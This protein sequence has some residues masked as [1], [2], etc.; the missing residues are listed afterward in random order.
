MSDASGDVSLARLAT[1]LAHSLRDLQ[2]EL[3]DGP[4]R[5]RPP[6]PGELVEFTDEV[7]IPAVI[8]LLETNIRALQLLQRA[9][10]LADG[11]DAR[12]AT[13]ATPVRD[14]AIQLSQ[15]T[16]DRLDTVLADVQD[17]VEGQ[18][19]DEESRELLAEARK[20]RAEI[21][22]RLAAERGDAPSATPAEPSDDDPVPVD[23]DSELQSLRDDLDDADDGPE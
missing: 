22:E 13:D 1:D 2:R 21:D 20:L 8:L 18:P 10:R 11:R 5:P 16:L 12:P 23:I 6:T 17:A 4:G 19:P 7:A 15:A 3:D 14:R 9:L